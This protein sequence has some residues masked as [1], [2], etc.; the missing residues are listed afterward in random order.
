LGFFHRL[1]SLPG[2]DFFEWAKIKRRQA[3]A[4][5]AKT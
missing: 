4:Y 3:E 2:L 1:L 5:A